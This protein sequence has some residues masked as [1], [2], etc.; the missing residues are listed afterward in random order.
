MRLFRQADLITEHM[1]GIK[2]QN[3]NSYG[4]KE[5]LCQSSQRWPY[6]GYNM[7]SGLVGTAAYLDDIIVVG[8]SREELQG[9]VEKF[10][11]SIKKYGLI[12]GYAVG[13]VICMRGGFREAKVDAEFGAAADSL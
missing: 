3:S 12:N 6:P 7:I 8:D 2:C 4:R 11:E 10:L 13:M 5:G 1:A 9:L